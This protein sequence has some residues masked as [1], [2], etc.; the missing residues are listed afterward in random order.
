MAS[1]AVGVSSLA[2]SHGAAPSA[3]V[4]RS[5]RSSAP[6]A[7]RA[8]VERVSCAFNPEPSKA[9]PLKRKEPK[10][11]VKAPPIKPTTVVA[12]EQTFFEGPPSITETLI[13]GLSVFTVVGIIPFTASLAR[14]AWTRYKLTNR[15]IEVASGFQGKDVVQILWREVNDVKWL[16]RYGGSAGDIVLTL[17][18][19]AKVE[20]RSMPEFDRN[21]AFMMSMVDEEVKD[22]AEYPDKPARD[23][24]DKVARGEEEPA[25]LSEDAPV[26]AA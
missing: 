23:F 16:R 24:A 4:A 7:Y 1:S 9:R 19:G 12:V 18:D 5:C 21:L 2:L 3:V 17:R 13:P 8:P 15:R 6:A 14:Q 10:Q 25:T 11:K 26:P 22:I 20:M